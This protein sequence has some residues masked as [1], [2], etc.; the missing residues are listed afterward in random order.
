MVLALQP[1]QFEKFQPLW[2]PDTLFATSIVV[3]SVAS[4]L[5]HSSNAPWVHHVDLACME[6]RDRS[7]PV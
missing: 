1:A 5:W 6:V 3:L 2:V 7:A 4:F